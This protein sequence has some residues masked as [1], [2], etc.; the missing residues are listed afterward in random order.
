MAPLFV[1]YSGVFGGAERVLVDFVSRLGEPA[2]LACPPGALAERAAPA[3]LQVHAF[4]TRSLNVR[5]GPW[6]AGRA[7]GHIVGF[8]RELRA[9]N[10]QWRPDAIVL[11][12]MRAA[13][14]GLG[15]PAQRPPLVFAHHDMLPG[16]TIGRLVRQV[17]TR[18]DAVVVPSAAVAAQLP[19]I[20][21]EIIPPGIDLEE[22][23]SQPVTPAPSALMLGAIVGWKRPDLALEIVARAARQLPELRLTVVGAPIDGDLASA[24]LLAR[25]RSRATAPDLGGRVTFAGPTAEPL[26]ALRETNCL[27]HCADVEPFGLVLVEAMAAGRP[28]VAPAAGGPM[29]IVDSS[30]ARLYRP[31][32]A[33]SGAAALVEVLADR[34]CLIDLGAAARERAVACF[35]VDQAAG[36]FRALLAR[37]RG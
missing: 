29:E 32:D 6:T 22:F 28:V 37:V 36:R 1:S 30:C 21:C 31:G 23:S 25:L 15:L 26:A 27:L 14:A 8:A 33:E 16:P 18:C 13:L 7:L 19:G 4:R 11:W 20:P 35:D 3:G 9:A 12:G 10:E 5:G 2:V 17:A 34:E 24:R